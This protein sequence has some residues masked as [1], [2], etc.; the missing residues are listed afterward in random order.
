MN[1]REQAVAMD[2]THGFGAGGSIDR[3][4]FLND[5]AAAALGVAGLGT[6]VVTT[7]YLSPNVLFEP[8]TT[9]RIGL[10][11][12][13]PMNSVT[14]IADQQVY[15]V[16]MPGGFHAISAICTHLGCITQWK[17]DLDSIACPCHG[18][19]FSKEGSV[20]H[21]PAPQPL[22]HYALRLMPDGDLQVDKL[23]IVPQTQILKV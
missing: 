10:P 16:R 12:G 19:Q 13:Y 9:F 7:R 20:V 11:D 18:S 4:D 21:G 8:P 17:P 5:I 3:R 22:P 15:I 23:E 6:L 14:Y 1:E 2:Q